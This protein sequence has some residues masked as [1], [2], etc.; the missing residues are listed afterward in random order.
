MAISEPA[1]QIRVAD[2]VLRRLLSVRE[3]EALVKKQLE[4]A[5]PKSAASPG[6]AAV[7]VD[8]NVQAA[9]AQLRERLGTKVR[10]HRSG[11]R[12]R[13]EIEFY[14]DEELDRLFAYI[15]ERGH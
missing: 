13:I 12:G 7:A 5:A 4:P 3:T 8:P 2:E 9:E 15:M 14:S 1:T 10:I 11:K 6:G